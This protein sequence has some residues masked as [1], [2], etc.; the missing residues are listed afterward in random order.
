M[1]MP[2]RNQAL[3]AL[4]DVVAGARLLR[5]LPAFLRRPVSAEDAGAVLRDRLLRREADFL[6]L[7]E[8][9]VFGDRGSPYRRLLARAGCEYGDL[10]RLVRQRGVEGTLS[11]LFH[12]GVYLTA[13]ELKGRRPVVRGTDA[14][15]VNPDRL[16]N[17]A[18]TSH[19]VGQSTGSGGPRTPVRIDLAS[20][21]DQVVDLRLYIEARRDAGSVHGVWGVPGGWIV[22]LLLRLAGCGVT[23]ARWF[24]QVDPAAPSL[25]PRYRWSARAMRW[26]GA[27]AGVRLPPPRHVPIEAPLP[28]GRWMAD[29]LRDGRVP[30]LWTYASSA[31]RLCRAAADAGID[32]RGA[33][34]SVSGEPATPA[35]LAA[36]REIGAEIVPRYGASD[37]GQIGFGCLAPAVVDEVHWLSDLHAL[38]QPLEPE[39][40]SR[41][42]GTPI[43]MSS[44][45]PTARLIL[46]NASLG[47]Q[48]VVTSR[49]CG[50]P[51]EQLGWSLH[52]HTIRSDE[53]VT[54]GGMN[55]SD[56]ELIRVLDEVLPARFGGAPTHYQ[57]VEDEGPDGQP[58]LRL[59]VHPLVGALDAHRVA[60]TFLDAIS[61]GSGVERVMGLAWRDAGVLRIERRPPLA[62]GT[63]KILH[64]HVSR[65]RTAHAVGV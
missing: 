13:D 21:W 1:A 44:L 11:V 28:I 53:K 48:A 3:A 26:G 30:H 47:D 59:L 64:L 57:L 60:E 49:G 25:H 4:E 8:H 58:Q 9:A 6:A 41:L 42:P 50:C 62:T 46:L 31:T 40:G 61:H 17:P 35:R 2:T 32:L 63:G 51:F 54:A 22:S 14:F 34:F 33:R 10:E 36:V 52:A 29:V 19:L 56:A 12:A 15:L 37:C 65:G 16:R 23:P 18:A 27:L 55:F 7:V 43:F 20:L 45:R 5:R 38:I 39:P 24:S